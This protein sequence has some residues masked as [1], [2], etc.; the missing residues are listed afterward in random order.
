MPCALERDRVRISTLDCGWRNKV[1]R[2]WVRPRVAQ[3]QLGWEGTVGGLRSDLLLKTPSAG[4]PDQVAQIFVPSALV[5]LQGQ[6]WCCLSGTLLTAIPLPGSCKTKCILS[7]VSS[8]PMWFCLEPVLLRATHRFPW[9]NLLI[10]DS[11]LLMM[12]HRDWIRLSMGV[13]KQWIF[14]AAGSQKIKS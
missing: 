3:S 9:L 14:F 7:P 13:H 11:N 2:F 12:Q 4:R 5:N 8:A 6:R 1:V 10:K